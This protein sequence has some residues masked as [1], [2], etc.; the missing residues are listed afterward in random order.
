MAPDASVPTDASVCSTCDVEHCID[1][2]CVQ[3]TQA[4]EAVDCDTAS[5]PVCGSL[6]QC[7]A[8][9]DSVRDCMRF[10]RRPSCA[11]SGPLAGQCVSCS[12]ATECGDP[13][14]P[15]CDP[16]TGTCIDCRTDDD[17][18]RFEGHHVCALDGARSGRCVECVSDDDCSTPEAAR[19]DSTRNTC[20]QCDSRT[21]CLAQGLN[22]CDRG[23]CVECTETTA[24]THCGIYS[25]DP[26]EGRCTSTRRQSLGL[27]ASCLS[28]AECQGDRTACVPTEFRGEPFGFFCLSR[29]PAGGCGFHEAPLR[30]P[31]GDRVSRSSAPLSDYCGINEDLTTCDAVR[32]SRDL[33]PCD[34]S[35]DCPAGGLCAYI[36]PE[37]GGAFQC[38]YE[39]SLRIECQDTGLLSGCEGPPGTPYCGRRL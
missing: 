27:C 33:L 14:A 17:C 19:C 9:C 23:R 13:S 39:C 12:S 20:T 28:D 25:C 4:T 37:G 5:A 6:N 3:C 2:R 29:P 18:G 8:E 22:E 21:T 15:V 1:G 26:I 16:T 11:Q 32:L 34:D 24:A 7:V 35:E 36:G 31:L 38:T 10:S 30:V